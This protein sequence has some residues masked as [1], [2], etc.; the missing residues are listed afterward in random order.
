MKPFLTSGELRMVFLLFA[1]TC[2]PVFA[3]ADELAITPT[4]RIELF[5]GHS[6]SGWTFVSQGTN[7][8]A[9][10]IWSVTN[11]VITCLG[12]P[13]G[14]ARTLRTYRDYQLH[15]EWRFPAGPGNSGVFLHLNPPDQ[16][17]PTCLE[18]QL[19][20]GDAGE[21]RCNGDSHVREQT[22]PSTI[23]VPRR[24]PSSENP[25]GEWN[26]Y[27]IVCRSNTVSVRVNGV[28]QNEVTGASVSAGAI[29]LQAEGKRVEFRNLVIEPLP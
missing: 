4:N 20:S 25:V 17:W 6:F 19:L 15:A 11:G 21:I 27:D 29:G 24:Q 5:D 7:A 18:A 3:P 22:S 26:R 12:K 8:P 2:F 14:Y 9:A 13:N 10:A 28:L 1:T 23:A 16:V